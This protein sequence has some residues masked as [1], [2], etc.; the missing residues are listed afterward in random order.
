MLPRHQ[1]LG[2]KAT[3]E[4]A[5]EAEVS[6]RGALFIDQELHQVVAPA[7]E[8][9]LRDVALARLRKEGTGL[10]FYKGHPRGR[11]RAQELQ[12]QGLPVI[13][14]TGP[15]S[16]EQLIATER[17]AAVVG[18]YSTT[19]MLLSDVDVPRRVAVF[20]DPEDPDVRRPSLVRAA[21]API[22]ASGATVLVAGGKGGQ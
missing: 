10:L 1:A 7:L 12:E 8:R 9:K 14:R 4:S 13:D 11:N 16:A 18:F 19:L 22:E 5:N 17:I 2:G 3:A 20:P 6:R 21:R 15:V